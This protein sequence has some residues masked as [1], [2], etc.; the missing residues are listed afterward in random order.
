MSRAVPTGRALEARHRALA[1][2]N[3]ERLQPQLPS[4][5]WQFEH[6]NECEIREQ[7]AALLEV[8]R[9]LVEPL[10]VGVPTDPDAFMSWYEALK[11]VGPGQGDP[12]FGW[13]ATRATLDQMRWFLTQEAAGEA[14][15][16]DLV[17]MTQVRFPARAKLELARNY[18]DEMGR[19]HLDGM[20]GRMLERTIDAMALKP[21]L[22]TTVWEALALSNTMIAMATNR[23]FAF[24][25]IGALGAIEMTA[26]G[27]VS[28]VNAG[29][30]RLGAPAEARQYFQ[31]H[32]GLDVRHSEAWNREVIRPLVEERPEVASAI[33]EGA[34][35]RLHC[36]ARMFE[37]YRR[38]LKVPRN[39]VRSGPT[40]KALH[41]RVA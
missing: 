14:G 34:L 15:F 36:G 9:R 11:D 8:E 21:A 32:A 13:L 35:L 5:A 41:D 26:P 25:S 29:L 23:R 40:A 20:H 3:H 37:R 4:P 16:D 7:E 2:L 33:A 31:L 27:R 22:E 12:L 39:G 30:K 6:E 28:Q 17:A 18:W 38:Q 24:H 1:A 19:G 10:L